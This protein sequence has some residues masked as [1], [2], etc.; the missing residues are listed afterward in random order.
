MHHVHHVRAAIGV[1]C[2]LPPSPWR[3][4]ERGET[5]VC[6]SRQQSPSSPPS[7]SGLRGSAG[8]STQ[9]LFLYV[10]C[11]GAGLK[12]ETGS[13]VCAV[14]RARVCVCTRTSA[15]VRVNCPTMISIS[16]FKRRTYKKRNTKQT[17][18][19]SEAKQVTTNYN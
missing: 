16:F 17:E 12:L 14:A 15:C 19:H 4:S 18:H 9:E 1:N 6:S 2:F 7:S 5:D 11:T 3:V 8:D 10:S 13:V